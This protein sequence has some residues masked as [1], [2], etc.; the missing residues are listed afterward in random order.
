M[1]EKLTI[2]KEMLEKYGQEQLLSCYNRMNKSK[3]DELLNEILTTDFKKVNQL[4]ATTKNKKEDKNSKIEPIEHISKDKL[5]EEEYEKYQKIGEQAIKQGKLAVVTMAGGQGTRL[6]HTGP[7]GTYDIGL[8]SHKSIFEILCDNF[9]RAKEKYGVCIPWYI[10]TSDE[11]NEETVKFFDENN[12]FGYPKTEVY[13]FRQ[14][15]LPM[16]DQKGKI[17][18]NEEGMIKQAADGHG[19]VLNAMRKNGVIYD[20]K[21]RN[22]EWV[23]ISGVDNILAKFIDPVFLGAQISNQYMAASKSVVKAYANEKVGVFCKRNGRPSVIEYTEISEELASEVD[24]KGEF[25]LGDS[26]IV[27]HQFS[28]DILEELSSE[29]LPYHRAFKKANYLGKDGKVINVNEPNAY[30]FEAFIFDVFEQVSKMLVF[31]VKREEEFAPI[32]NA[33]GKD[34]PDTAKKLYEEFYKDK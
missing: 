13:F 15:K 31:R 20:M 22:I 2:A 27:N 21:E 10:M 11:N 4:F 12:Y 16:I 3:Q 23:F 25:L 32:K 34:S 6:G 9:K 5:T 14:G 18:L 7:K 26:N 33:E 8:E 29:K 30:K 28:I 19:G 17:L 24:S 1:E